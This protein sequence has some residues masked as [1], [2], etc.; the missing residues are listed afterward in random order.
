[1]YIKNNEQLEK[2]KLEDT[3]VELLYGKYGDLV[4]HGGTAIWRCYSGNRFSRDI[5]FY[6]KVSEKDKHSNYRE[7]S[8]FLKDCGFSIKEKGY[9][10]ATDTMHFL[11]E[12]NAK[13]K[14][15]INFKYKNGIPAEYK[16]VDDSRI[17]VLSLAPE[18]LLNEKID[19]YNYKLQNTSNQNQPEVQDLYDLYYLITLIK[20][21][22]IT[23]RN[24]RELL[25][26]IRKKPPSNMRSLDHLILAGLP[27]TFEFMIEKLMEWANDNQ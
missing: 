23:K 9:N 3:I 4:L 1:M 19:V 27:P 6:Q 22:E 26:H 18:E 13:M 10:N 20:G 8:E 24:L 16:K 17:M 21:K 11:V 14:I 12:S 5:D 7:I 15:D 2:A 25:K